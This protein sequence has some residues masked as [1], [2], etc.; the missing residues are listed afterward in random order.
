MFKNKKDEKEPIA[1]PAY[2]D[3]IVFSTKPDVEYTVM[4]DVERKS[5]RTIYS[6][7]P[8]KKVKSLG[9]RVLGKISGWNDFKSDSIK[10]MR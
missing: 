6:G 8:N 1:I 7:T 10:K 5:G 9:N 4:V 2:N 3:V